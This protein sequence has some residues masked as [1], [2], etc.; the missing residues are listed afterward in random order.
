MV[1]VSSG[2][3]NQTAN[4]GWRA[5]WKNRGAFPESAFAYAICAVVVSR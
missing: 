3:V 4:F 1:L 5:Q 2:P